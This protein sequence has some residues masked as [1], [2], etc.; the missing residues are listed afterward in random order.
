MLRLLVLLGT[1]AT[2]ASGAK[3]KA[4]PIEKVTELLKGLQAKVAEEGKKEAAAYD[5]FAC[6]CKEQADEK[7]YAIEK[8]DALI[9]KLTEEIKSLDAD[10]AELNGDISKLSQKASKLEKKIEADAKARA[11]E[12]A[13]YLVKAQ[14]LNEAIGA[15]TAA[16]AAMK[17]AKSGL[18]DAK[19]N[20]AQVQSRLMATVSRQKLP[21]ETVALVE[22]LSQPKYQ[23]QGNDIIA[24]LEDLLA[25]FKEM[26]KNLDQDEF[27]LK[28]VFDEEA[29][30]DSNQ[31]KFTNKEKDEKAA[32]AE[33]KT[34]EVM[35]KREDNDQ[36]KKDRAAD[37]AFMDVLTK[38]CEEKATLFD[39][40]SKTRADELTAMTDAIKALEEGVKPNEGANKKLVGF[41]QIRQVGT[42]QQESQH[43]I[44]RVE[45]L[46]Q[47]AA[48]TQ[49]S[50]VLRGAA[51]RVE[52][53]QDHFVKVRGLIKD[54]IQRLKDDAAA[55][56]EQKGFCD[57]AMKEAITNRDEGK[58][59]QET[60][61]SKKTT[62]TALSEEL[63][64]SIADLTQEIAE[65]KKAINEASEL[66]AGEKADN[67]VTLDQAE[68]GKDA[69]N[70]AL[71]VLS[72]FYKNAFMQT[73]SKYVP[74][75]SDREGNTV[76]D[77]APE[78][79]DDK[80]HGA[81]GE[82]KGIIGILE[83]IVSDFERSIKKV[84]EDEK[85]AQEAFEKF[86][87]ET[88]EDCDAMQ[89]TIDEKEGKLKEAKADIV[90]QIQA[91]KDAT[92]LF[93]SG[94]QKLEELHATCV[95]GEETWEERAAARK[96]EIEALK[97]AQTVLDEWQN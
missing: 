57:K 75:N 23:F 33:E 35:N 79:F 88:N 32:L 3:A 61:D 91:Y 59:K 72:D 15:C 49:G 5:K 29:L 48:A 27:D 51:A 85:S 1:V 34:E 60:A 40:R 11:K 2:V 77:L 81:Q 67:E 82:A 39:Q 62:L 24:T 73:G 21:S 76:G 80:Y 86:E 42:L 38:D 6:F 44:K 41:I 4:T 97:E 31:L 12:H 45:E 63:T 83:V 68:Q 36:E 53:S 16:I 56:A 64:N 8:S 89:K 30:G 25:D 87:K 46:L 54:L 58:G 43:A 26:K 10:I 78:V 96:K 71:T 19:V 37:Q 17:D 69:T 93:E 18:K 74:P 9:A 20:F 95:A 14:D 52:L 47:E 65:N 50:A 7:L 90:E 28:S 13:K 94:E 92:E 84:T 22:K 66:R 55:E 70:M